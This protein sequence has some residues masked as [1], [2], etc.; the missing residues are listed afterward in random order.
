VLAGAR[1][2]AAIADWAAV[3]DHAVAVCG[4]PP[5]ASTIRRLLSRL[6]A[7]ALE[8]ALTGWVLARRQS[9]HEVTGP[10]AEHR[11][12][13]AVDGKTL[14]GARGGDGRQTKLVCVYDQAQRLVLT[15]TGVVD[16]DEIAAFT[17]ALSTLPDLHEVLVTADALHCQREHAAWLHARGGHYLFT[18]KSNQ[19]ALRR[20]L[21][22]LPGGQVPGSRRR[23]LGHG[24]SES[25]SIKVVDLDGHGAADR[26]PHAARAIK[27]VRSRRRTATGARSIEVVYAVTSLTYRQAHPGLLA[28]WIQGH[29]AIENAVHHGRDL[30][31]GEDCSSVPAGS[32]PPVMA[33]LR[34]TALNLNRLEGHIN[35]ARAQRQASWQPG[36]ALKAIHAA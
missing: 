28:A 26:F 21:A 15:Q 35:I 30:T 24:R 36:T 18:V 27:V 8:A 33:A 29:W 13:L 10:V 12:V 11:P 17:A 4:P 34:N 3:A 16:G 20:A 31:R 7:A 19:P 25:R 14:R 9:A 32:G 6:D 23:Q 1:C 2:Y 22:A 5:H